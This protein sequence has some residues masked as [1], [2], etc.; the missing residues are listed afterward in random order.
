MIDRITSNRRVAVIGVIMIAL[1]VVA[2]IFFMQ[3][4]S[5]EDKKA[6][7]ET[8]KKSAEI[9]WTNAIVEYDIDELQRQKDSLSS[10]AKFPE[11]FPAAGLAIELANAAYWNSVSVEISQNPTKVSTES[12]GGINYDA[13]ATE[14]SV[15]GS[16]SKIISFLDYIERGDYSSIRVQDV[17]FKGTEV[18]GKLTFDLVLLT[19]R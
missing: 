11:N 8:D 6:D 15:T 2:V 7:V 17:E 5:A 12:V 3:W 19:L 1:V 10:S 16:L 9:R 14:V 18:K 13:Y 4:Q